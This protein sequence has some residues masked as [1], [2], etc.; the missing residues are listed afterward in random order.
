MKNCNLADSF[1]G[2]RGEEQRLRVFEN[3]ALRK[4]FGPKKKHKKDGENR[5]M[6]SLIMFNPH[7]I[8]T[9]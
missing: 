3:T 8:A 4:I 9:G 7:H 6:W 5:K 2:M 1:I